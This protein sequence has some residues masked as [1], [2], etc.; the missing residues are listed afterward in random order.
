MTSRMEDSEKKDS[1]RERETMRGP[2]NRLSQHHYVTA[3]VEGRREKLTKMV[4]PSKM[5]LMSLAHQL[6]S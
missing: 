4:D 2:G 6:E 3:W 5:P 1:K